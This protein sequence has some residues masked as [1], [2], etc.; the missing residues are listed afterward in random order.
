M[1]PATVMMMTERRE[2]RRET[3]NRRQV[4]ERIGEGW[5]QAECES[6]NDKGLMERGR[7]TTATETWTIQLTVGSA[8][9]HRKIETATEITTNSK[10]ETETTHTDRGPG[11]GE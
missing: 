9:T 10:T 8:R 7:T 11:L 2:R 3:G 4:Q 5:E 1:W 6:K